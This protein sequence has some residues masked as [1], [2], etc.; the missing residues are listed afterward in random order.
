MNTETG[1]N[2]E[3][4]LDDEHRKDKVIVTIDG[5]PKEIHRGSYVVAELKAALGVDPTR[6]LNVVIDG[7]LEPLDDTKRFVIRGG[8]V[9][10]SQ[11]PQGGSS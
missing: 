10:I 5:A 8:E 4:H 6:L 2:E 11:V 1:K 9:F 3:R 7:K